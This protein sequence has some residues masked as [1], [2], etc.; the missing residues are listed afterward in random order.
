V[1]RARRHVADG[2]PKSRVG[3]AV[4]VLDEQLLAPVEV[5][6]DVGEERVEP[7][8]GEWLVYLPPVDVLI[9]CALADD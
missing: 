9:G 4:E 6:A 2:K 1:P 7:V 5:R 8:L 3:A